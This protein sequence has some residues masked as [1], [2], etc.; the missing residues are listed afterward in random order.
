MLN[1]QMTGYTMSMDYML[2]CFDKANLSCSDVADIDLY[3][4]LVSGEL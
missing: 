2:D 3:N 4:Y 1:K